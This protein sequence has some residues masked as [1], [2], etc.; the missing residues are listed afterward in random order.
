MHR[1][2][3]SGL[4]MEFDVSPR[5]CF[6]FLKAYRGSPSSVKVL[7]EDLSRYLRGQKI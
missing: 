2:Y 4:K 5:S 6:G 7:G 1:D 3:C